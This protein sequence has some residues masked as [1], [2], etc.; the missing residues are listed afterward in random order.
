MEVDQREWKSPDILWKVNE[1][2]YTAK[3]IRLSIEDDAL[4]AI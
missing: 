3:D 1:V 2:Q 4:L